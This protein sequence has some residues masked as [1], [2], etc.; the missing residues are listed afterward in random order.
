MHTLQAAEQAIDS[1]LFTLIFVTFA[2]RNPAAVHC[3]HLL[4]NSTGAG[5]FFSTLFS[6]FVMFKTKNT[7]FQTQCGLAHQPNIH[8]DFKV[9]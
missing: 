1:L 4:E 5:F 6:I 7:S 2:L 9:Y 3:V 8:N